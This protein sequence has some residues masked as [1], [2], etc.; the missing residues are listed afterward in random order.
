MDKK[1]IC[2]G[3][4]DCFSLPCNNPMFECNLKKECFDKTM[5][6]LEDWLLRETLRDC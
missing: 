4:Q 1:P 6:I 2:F 5:K 3:K